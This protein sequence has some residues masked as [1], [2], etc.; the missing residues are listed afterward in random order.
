M[1]NFSTVV[2]LLG[3]AIILHFT[4]VGSWSNPSAA[5]ASG[6]NPPPCDGGSSMGTCPSQPMEACPTSIT[7]YITFGSFYDNRSGLGQ[8]CVK[9]AECTA[10]AYHSP[11]PDCKRP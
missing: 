8:N 2:G 3:L 5:W 9:T 6:G 1:R 7:Y 11:D 10:W 4:A